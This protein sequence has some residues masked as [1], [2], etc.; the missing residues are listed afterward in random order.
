VT[1]I[2]ANF[3]GRSVV[4]A[5]TQTP[6]SGPLALVT[7]P[8]R[9]LAPMRGLESAPGEPLGGNWHAARRRETTK[10]TG[11]TELVVLMFSLP[12]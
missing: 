12:R 4:S 2:L 5:I 1:T 8:P 6:A 3:V 10:V 11:Y 9:S 7:V